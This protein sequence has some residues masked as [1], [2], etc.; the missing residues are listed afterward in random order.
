MTRRDIEELELRHINNLHHEEIETFEDA[1]FIVH[2]NTIRDAIHAN[3]AKNFCDPNDLITIN[4]KDSG[5]NYLTTSDRLALWKLPDTPARLSGLLH[6]AP[7]MKVIIRQNLYPG[8]QIANGTIG[9][10]HC[11]ASNYVGVYFQHLKNRKFNVHLPKGVLPIRKKSISFKWEKMNISRR[12]YPFSLAKALTVHA[13]QGKTLDKA[14]V[15][16]SNRMTLSLLYVALSRVSFL[17]N[18]ILIGLSNL[19][20]WI[21]RKEWPENILEEV[22]RIR[23]KQSKLFARMLRHYPFLDDDV[24]KE[25]LL[26]GLQ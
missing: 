18:L 24:F 25:E 20:S 12:Q 13:V 8:L 21:Q 6:L 7:G 22:H 9:T 1:T 11:V 26:L 10:I 17:K 14:V 3:Y 15:H 19:G 4:T 16:L 2:D 5:S 23:T